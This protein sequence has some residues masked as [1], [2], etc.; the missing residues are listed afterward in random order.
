MKP[1]KKVVVS[2]LALGTLAGALLAP[3]PATAAHVDNALHRKVI[4]ELNGFIAWL[5]EHAA[6]GFVGETGWPDDHYGDADR[7]NDLAQDW[8]E[9]ADAAN[10]GAV[11]WATG[12]WWPTNYKLAVYENRDEVGGVESAN[13]QASV[14]EAHLSTPS[15]MRG[16]NVSTGTF[17]EG[18]GTERTS[19]FSNHDTGRYNVC[20]RYDGQETFDYLAARGHDLVKIEFRWEILQRELGEP[21]HPKSIERLEAV[22]DRARTAGLKV[23]LSM[24]NFGAYWLWDGERGVRRPIGSAKVSFGDFADVW[25]RLSNRFREVPNVYYAIMSEPVALEPRG[26]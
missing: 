16:M 17:C 11:V 6:P 2:M 1:M 18:H 19:S 12:E 25:R 10:L 4:S 20:Y 5:D 24:H 3:S 7:W 15:Y 22:V 21:L 9:V 14:L 13:T 8:F 23:V 26:E